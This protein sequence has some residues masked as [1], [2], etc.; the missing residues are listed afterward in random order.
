MKKTVSLLLILILSLTMCAT[1][2]AADGDAQLDAFKAPAAGSSVKSAMVTVLDT[3]NATEAAVT[4]ESADSEY[5]PFVD[6]AKQMIDAATTGDYEA[7]YAAEEARNAKIAEQELD[8]PEIK[9]DDFML[10]AKIIWAEAGSEWLDDEWKMCVGEVVLNR[11]AS[12]E[13]PDTVKEVLEQPGQYYGANSRYFS[14]IIP[15]E[16]CAVAAMRLFNGER[17]INDPSVVFQANFRQGGGVHTACYDK[18]LG[19]TYFCYSRNT[20]LY[21]Q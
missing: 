16:R 19:W 17:V 15:T 3:A 10:I 2:T 13:F 12:P 4:P 9:F 11:V 7:G 8:Y 21:E 18:Y 20:S 5:D 14:S 1:A 6:Y